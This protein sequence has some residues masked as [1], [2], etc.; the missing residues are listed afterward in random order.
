MARNKIKFNSRS[1]RQILVGPGVSG[2]V[3]RESHRMAARAGKGVVA[4]T[5]LGSFGGGRTVGIV[6]TTARTPEQAETQ[7]ERLESAAHGG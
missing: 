2:V 6:T 4:K 3:G 7:R 1:F 5:M